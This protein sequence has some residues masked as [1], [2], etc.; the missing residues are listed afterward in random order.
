LDYTLHYRSPH[1]IGIDADYALCHAYLSGGW[2]TFLIIDQQGIVRFHE[3]PADKELTGLRQCLDQWLGETTP[4]A[5]RPTVRKPG[6]AIPAEVL[7]GRLA[8]RDRSPRLAF[9]RSGNPCVVFYSN[10]EGTN[11]IF[12]RRFNPSG[13]APD[14][15]LS[16]P[17]AESYAA[18]CGYETNG[19]LW[20]AW[21]G[22]VKGLYD[23]FIHSRPEGGEP[24]TQQLTFSLEDAMSPRIAIGPGGSATVAYYKW[25]TLWGTSRD[26]DVFARTFDPASRT[27]RPEIEISPH[28]PEVEDHTDPDVAIDRQG[29]PWIVWSYDYHPSLFPKPLDAAQPTV[30]AARVAANTVS[31]PL[32][33]GATGPYRNAID[34]F[35]SAATDGQGALWCAWDSS[36]PDRCIRLARFDEA[37][38]QFQLVNTFGQKGETCSTPELT[39]A[40]T[41]ELL[42]SW[43]RRGPAGRWQ[44]KV[45]VLKAGKP[46]AETI[47]SENADVLFP[48]AQRSADGRYWVA[49]EKSDQ[50][51]SDIVLRNITQELR[52]PPSPPAGP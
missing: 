3:A 48:Q 10:R 13:T 38:R 40:S 24:V 22:K 6:I 7:A 34:L 28:E 11:A 49:Y 18:D 35:P 1:M 4:A 5:A 43:S 52:R 36:E 31:P 37:S 19:T 50:N 21:C 30:F 23:I 39:S 16:P 47:L 44:G 17:A 51:G 20:V 9:D 27:W 41:D 33:V 45:V 2:P 29:Q 42:L 12:L 15:R 14:E 8:R 32:L 26:R 25:H 46:F